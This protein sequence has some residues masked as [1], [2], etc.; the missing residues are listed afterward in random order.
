MASTLRRVFQLRVWCPLFSVVQSDMMTLES[1]F[2]MF[3]VNHLEVARSL[4]LFKSVTSRL[5]DG[6]TRA[7]EL[8]AKI[9]AIGQTMPSVA[10]QLKVRSSAH[11]AS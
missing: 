9:A 2:H 5:D 3:E 8:S 4:D 10:G 6:E 11:T 7:S 1:K